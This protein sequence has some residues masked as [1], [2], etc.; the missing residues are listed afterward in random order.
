[1]PK[2]PQPSSPWCLGADPLPTDMHLLITQIHAY[3]EA[4]RNIASLHRETC[5]CPGCVVRKYDQVRHGL[6]RRAA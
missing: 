1:M 4:R 5:T 3:A 6:T 2:R